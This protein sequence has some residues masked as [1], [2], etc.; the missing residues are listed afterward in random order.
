MTRG[1]SSPR[2]HITPGTTR[3]PSPYYKGLPPTVKLIAISRRIGDGTSFYAAEVGS[4]VH[5]CMVRPPLSVSNIQQSP[6]LLPLLTRPLNSAYCLPLFIQESTGL[7][8]NPAKTTLI[9]SFPGGSR[10]PSI[11]QYALFSFLL[12]K[13]FWISDLWEET[14]AGNCFSAACYAG[15]GVSAALQVI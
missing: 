6:P 13:S 12:S 1:L 11:L 15:E 4:S 9:L 8:G 2:H 5:R 3:L 14:E 10:N 7:R